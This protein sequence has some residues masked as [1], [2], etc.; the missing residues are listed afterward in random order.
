MLLP[1]NQIS[2]TS[3][4]GRS[5]SVSGLTITPHWL[6]AIRPHDT[7]ATSRRCDYVAGFFA[8]ISGAAGRRDHIQRAVEDSPG[9]AIPLGV[10]HRFLARG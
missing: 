5:S 10:D 3:P 6:R 4:S 7:C 8:A 1:C 9:V 2:P